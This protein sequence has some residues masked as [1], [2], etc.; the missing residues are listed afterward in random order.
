[1]KRFSEFDIKAGDS[2]TGDK[3]KIDK[4]LNR[5]IT[6]H[7]YKMEDSKYPKNKSGKCLYLQIE[8][9]G[10]MLIIFSGSDFL[11]N[12][13]K[14]IEAE[15]FPFIATIIKSNDHFEFT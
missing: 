5:E 12:Q 6:V 7:K 14:Q 9:S 13:L 2:F 4:I 1:M 10:S 11:M 8:L 15:S 3:I